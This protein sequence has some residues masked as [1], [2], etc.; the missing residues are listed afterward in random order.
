MTSTPQ[1]LVDTTSRPRL[2][3][4]DGLRGVAAL[5]VVAHP[6][7]LVLPVM[8][9]IQDTGSAAGGPWWLWIATHTCSPPVGG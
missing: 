9:G 5:V 7:L 4:L 3:S 8:V 2:R 1:Q 6:V